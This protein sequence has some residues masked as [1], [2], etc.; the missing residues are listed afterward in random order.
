MTTEPLPHGLENKPDLRKEIAAHPFLAGMSA[1]YLELLS[2]YA[3]KKQFKS[4]EIIF[5]AGEP[6]HG[7]YLVETGKIA[8]EGSVMEHDPVAVDIVQS[9]E[10]LG[11]SWLFPP[12]RWHF[13]ARA[14]EATTVIYF[15]GDILRQHYD[16]YLTLAHDLFKRMCEVMV[17]RLQ[18]TRR[19]LV[20]TVHKSRL[21][22][23]CKSGA[24]TDSRSGVTCGASRSQKINRQLF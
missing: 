16:E 17:H 13:D 2:R 11:W 6:A 7:F 4:D 8:L 9:G 12:Y 10:P 5:R 18:T 3:T 1:P 23:K 19:K 14:I 21:S 20:E 15:D 24:L 22:A